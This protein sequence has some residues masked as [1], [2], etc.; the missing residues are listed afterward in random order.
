MDENDRLLIWLQTEVADFERMVES[1]TLESTL[2][3]AL[4]FS[5]FVTIISSDK[6]TL[7]G[8]SAMLTRLWET[9][10][11]VLTLNPDASRM[12]VQVPSNDTVM[13]AI[14][15]LA[16]IASM[17]FV[18]VIV[19]RLRFN[20]LVGLANYSTE[21]AAA[22]NDKEEDLDRHLLLSQSKEPVLQT[23]LDRLRK[24]INDSLGEAQLAVNQL[25]PIIAYM[26]IFRHLGVLTFLGALVASALWVSP[27]LAAGFTLIGVLAYGYPTL[28]RWVRDSALRK[29]GFFLV[30]AVLRRRR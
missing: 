17:F 20:S 22:F 16:L 27:V 3:G 15:C 4:A 5:A 11:S 2:I 30:E 29:H 19:A 7:R 6:A 14:A 12:L 25:R 1:Y 21:M 8:V 10:H 13:V 26:R 24:Q 23:R 18:A 28:D 9:S